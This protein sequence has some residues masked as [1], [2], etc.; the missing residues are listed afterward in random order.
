MYE[1]LVPLK[2]VQQE[3][4]SPPDGGENVHVGKANVFSLFSPL[5]FV[6]LRTDVFVYSIYGGKFSRRE[7]QSP[8]KAAA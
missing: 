3:F 8:R 1:L 6:N 5:L 7:K 2:T 4:F